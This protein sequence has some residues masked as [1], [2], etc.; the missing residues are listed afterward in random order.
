MEGWRRDGGMDVE[1]NGPGKGRISS[2]MK[3]IVFPTLVE[4][5][6]RWV[7]GWVDGPVEAAWM[8]G[9]TGGRTD[10]RMVKEIDGW[11][12]GRVFC[13]KEQSLGRI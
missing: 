5:E 6:E 12:I 4:W 1:G 9:Q 3:G 8:A 11:M 2:W 10:G 13:Y 7:G